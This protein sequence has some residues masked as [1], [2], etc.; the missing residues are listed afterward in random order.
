M[1][2]VLFLICTANFFLV[3]SMMMQ[4]VTMFSRYSNTASSPVLIASGIATFALGLFAL[5][6][7][8]AFLVDRYG[9]KRTFVHSVTI[10][11][12]LS[13]LFYLDIDLLT[14]SL[15]RFIEGALFGLAQVALG[16]T[17]LN[18][19]TKSERRTYSDYSYSWAALFAI[20]VGF[21]LAIFIIGNWGNNVAVLAI[22]GAIFISEIIIFRLNIPFR[23]PIKTPTFS[24]DR[25]WQKNDI[26]PFIN[27]MA[28]S[29]A[30]GYYLSHL[31]H[32]LPFIFIGIGVVI[33]RILRVMIFANADVRAEIVSGML[34]SLAALLIPLA[35]DS[36]SSLKAS[37]VLFGAG[38]GITSSRFLLYF[39]KLIGHCQ[40]GT[41]QNTFMIS[42]ECGY[43]LGFVCGFIYTTPY[44]PVVIVLLALIFYITVTHPWFLKHNNRY[45]K[46]RE[47]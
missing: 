5:G 42:R 6:P 2:S 18:D 44:L 21:A 29:F 30:A 23:A 33:A 11:L 40:R 12:L 1:N 7:I 28:F 47:V 37:D 22:A 38:L 3:S 39:L 15:I 20:P 16:S 19:M 41:A 17:I 27:L 24:L 43:A 8:S 32:I 25:F 31:N 36:A 4:V 26:L 34:L 14:A 35:S 9:R 45:F 46:F 10:L 13:L